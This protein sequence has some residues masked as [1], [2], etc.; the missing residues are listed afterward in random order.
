[1]DTVASLGDEDMSEEELVRMVSEEQGQEE[2]HE[3]EVELVKNEGV[4]PKVL[5]DPGKP[6]K[7]ERIAN[8]MCH[9][10]YR[11]WCRHCVRGRAIG[12]QRRRI[13]KSGV[14]EMPRASID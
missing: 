10:P 5:I 8:E 11:S 4:T 14:P 7:Q 6:T 13:P 1:M 9:V 12:R 3:E 2:E